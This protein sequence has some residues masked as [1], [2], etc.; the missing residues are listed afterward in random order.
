M[1]EDIA[2]IFIIGILVYVIAILSMTLKSMWD[3]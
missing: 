2:T 3:P 1:S